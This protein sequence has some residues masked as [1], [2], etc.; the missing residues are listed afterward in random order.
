MF[1]FLADRFFGAAFARFAFFPLGGGTLISL[2]MA[3]SNGSGRVKETGFALGMDGRTT[4]P[5]ES[6]KARS[7]LLAQFAFLESSHFCN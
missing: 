1:H 4:L 7:Q 5:C 6:A 3:S 2:R